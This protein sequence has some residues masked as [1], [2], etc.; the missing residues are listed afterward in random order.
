MIASNELRIGNY[1]NTPYGVKRVSTISV[2][3]W[4]MHTESEPIP[5]TE[6][7]LLKFSF[8]LVYDSDFR[9]KYDY[10]LDYRFGFD[11]NKALKNTPE[12]INFRGDHFTE[13]KFVHQL[14]N[15]YFALTGK[16]LTFKN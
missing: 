5:L 16:E 7:W 4:S 12:G 14:Q 9:R 6:E 3:G 11:I 8:E 13:I 15:F 10:F 1:V 2:D